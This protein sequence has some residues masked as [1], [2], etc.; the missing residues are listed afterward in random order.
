MKREID[1]YKTVWAVV[2]CENERIKLETFKTEEEMFKFI[3]F[4]MFMRTNKSEADIKQPV[5]LNGMLEEIE[6]TGVP[7]SVFHIGVPV[8]LN[9]E[10][11]S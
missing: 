9:I 8:I 11:V 7:I 10:D 6:K 3:S 4:T 2:W 5:L 1:F